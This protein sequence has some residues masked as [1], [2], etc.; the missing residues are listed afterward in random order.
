MWLYSLILFLLQ[1]LLALYLL[2]RGVRQPEYRQ[3]WG[4]RFL[5]RLPE[6]TELTAGQKR[7]WVHAVSVGEAHAVSPLVQHWAKVYPQ[8]EWAFSCTTP[9]GLV[10]CRQLY[11]G[12]NNVRFFYLPYDL[13]YLMAR[14]FKQVQ[15]QAL[16]VVET[17]LWPN[18]LL[19][20]RAAGIS[21]ALLNARVSP[22]TGKRL[23]QLGFISR[24]VLQSLRKLI[25][26][27]QAD[28]DIF[29]QQ[30]RSADAVCGNLKFDV[31]LKT[32]LVL[33]GKAWRQAT[34]AEQIVLFASSREGEEV[35]LLDALNRCQFFKRMPKASV[36][37]V[38]RHPQRFDEV[39]DL[40]AGAATRL[41]VAR[42]VRRSDSFNAGNNIA[43]AGFSQARLVLGDSMGEMPAY[44]SVADLALL[45][46]SWLP[47]G[48]QNLI[49]ACA[50]GCPVW[51][52]PNTFNFAKAAD[53]ALAAQAA[54]RF[55]HL[56]A[57]CEYYLTEFQSSEQAKKAAF[58]YARGHRG[59]TQR[60]FD[61]LN[62]MI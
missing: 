33:V 59:A 53:D 21:T 55:E 15:A 51:M 22:R 31:A 13:P 45:G 42:P 24:P 57:A 60:S 11:A 36:W 44:Y 41:G 16:W 52:G 30:G 49:E 2:K 47:F 43:R 28:A 23:A 50:Y 29:H 32:E 14:T 54:R 56:L 46:G 17:E 18:L 1:P 8:H 12:L 48:G 34:Q 38:P 3:G 7:I 9:T 35:L 6:F 62:G 5:A 61:V 20:A 58:A 39:F 27:T 26:Q 10:T 40:M 37:I 4:Q 25:A 19:G